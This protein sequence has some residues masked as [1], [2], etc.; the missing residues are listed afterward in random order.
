MFGL[1]IETALVWVER[2]PSGFLHCGAAVDRMSPAVATAWRQVV[3]RVG[4]SVQ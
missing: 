4:I 3:D 1:S 2:A